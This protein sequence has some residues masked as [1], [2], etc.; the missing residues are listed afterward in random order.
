[1]QSSLFGGATVFLVFFDITMQSSPLG[2]ST[3]QSSLFRYNN[4]SVP[5]SDWGRFSLAFFDITMQSSLLGW[6]TVLLVFFDISM[7]SS[8]LGWI[9]IRSCL[10]D[11]WEC[12]VRIGNGSAWFFLCV[13]V[14]RC[15]CVWV[16]ECESRRRYSASSID[17]SAF[18]LPH[19]TFVNESTIEA[20]RVWECESVRVWAFIIQHSALFI[21]HSKI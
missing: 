5:C 13:C 20:V 19:S 10:F 8:L 3:V 15:V 12:P 7:Q 6:A 1:M 11:M 18:I 16:W 2:W 17:H 4:G 14:R 9:T 21:R